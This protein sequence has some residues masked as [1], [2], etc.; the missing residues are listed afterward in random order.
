MGH[1]L[2]H[3]EI[4]EPYPH[5]GGKQHGEPGG[6][7]ELGPGVVR[8]EPDVAV[9][10]EGQHQQQDQE[11]ADHQHIEPAEVLGDPALAA[12]EEAGGRLRRQGADGQQP[13]DE[14]QAGNEDGERQCASGRARSVHGAPLGRGTQDT[15]GPLFAKETKRAGILVSPPQVRPFPSLAEHR[16][17]AWLSSNGATIVQPERRGAL[18]LVPLSPEP[19]SNQQ[20]G[21]A[22]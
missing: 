15:I 16:G 9:A 6:E 10:A 22:R 4:H 13:Q 19:Q 3:P 7:A 14:E 17:A 12:A 5:A 11:H 20:R 2:A 1:G 21:F 8:P 18:S